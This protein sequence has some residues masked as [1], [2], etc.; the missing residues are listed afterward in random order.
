MIN[1]L[2]LLFA[3]TGRDAEAIIPLCWYLE[4]IYGYKIKFG[5]IFDYGYLIDSLKPDVLLMNNISGSEFNVSAASY[6]YDKKI[7]VISLVSE[8]LFRQEE[9]DEF[10]WGNNWD[11]KKNWDRMY[12]WSDKFLNMSQKA[13]PQYKDSF[14]I[15]GNTA[16]D[17]Y[18][19]YTF[20]KKEVLLK[21]YK[22]SKFKK[23][24]LYA[25]FGFGFYFE[26][27]D[28]TNILQRDINFF[29][30]EKDRVKEILQ[31]LITK[32]PEILFIL[33]KHPAEKLEN[34]DIDS[35]WN[36][37]NILILSDEEPLADLISLADLVLVYRSTT[38]FESYSLSK[39][40]INIFPSSHE[41]YKQEDQQGNVHAKNYHEL[42][43]FINEFYIKGKIKSFTDKNKIRQNLIK[44]KIFNDDGLNSSRAAKKIDHF[45]KSE[46]I[47]SNKQTSFK[48][49][50]IHF[51]LTHSFLLKILPRFR[52]SELLAKYEKFD[53]FYKLKEK[54]YPQ[55]ARFNKSK[56]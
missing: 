50:I 36:N 47:N 12:L 41:T 54:Y 2:V 38:T 39:T 11:H 45:I 7:K 48:N 30:K 17:R 1:I 6:A 22:K 43:K 3:P 9:I 55:I 51:L 49:Q 13:L 8:G 29:R 32:N 31:E 34:M 14:D 21:K 4:N 24:I 10:I 35:G 20:P 42:Q 28:L 16:I 23:I 26:W 25:G 44:D 19:I 52:R 33:K 56:K 27:G 5:S 15:S 46:K 18:K 40:V 37:E 53:S